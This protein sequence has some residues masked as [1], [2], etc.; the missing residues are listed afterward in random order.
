M[1][2]KLIIASGDGAYAEQLSKVLSDKYSHVF[3]VVLCSD[4]ER[5]GELLSRTKYDVAIMEPGF[6]T[7]E[8]LSAIKLPLL[9]WNESYDS[10]LF[11]ADIKKIKKYQ[12]I[13]SIAGT[14]LETF[15]ELGS[16]NNDLSIGRARITAVWS[17][18]GGTGK[19]SVALAYAARKVADGNHVTYLN[20]ESF[21]STP[22][23]FLE[24]G[25]SISTVFE[26]LETD[27]PMLLMGI[28]QQDS[29]S[30]ITYFCGPDNYDDVNILTVEDLN[31][32]ILACAVNTDELVVDLS[33]QCNEKTWKIF[34]LADTLLLV[35]D[36]SDITTA[37]VSQ[38]MSQHNI[39]AQVRDKCVLINNKNAGHALPGIGKS[40]RLPLVQAWDAISVYKTLSGNPFEW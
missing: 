5:F 28:R 21:S 14:V 1:K 29:G 26:K 39:A 37:K 35:C 7:P 3:E 34:E 25:K 31:R 36:T 27:V 30:G 11:P 17:P 4:N 10:A 9:L 20:M 23:Y 13:S 22:A 18:A 32:L 16:G 15:A 38:F 6:A 24:T 33:S 19:T 40:V 12:R 2:I 8:N